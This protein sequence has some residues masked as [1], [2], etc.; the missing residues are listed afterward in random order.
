MARRRSNRDQHLLALALSSQWQFSA[1]IAGVC[2]VGTYIGLPILFH[3]PLLAPLA[4]SLR[5]LGLLLAAVFGAIAAAK[6]FTGRTSTDVASVLNINPSTDPFGSTPPARTRTTDVQD[7][8]LSSGSVRPVAKPTA[9]SLDVLRSIEWKR[10][11]E[12]VAAYFREKGARTET[13]RCGADGGVD[14]TLYQGDQRIGVVQCKA[15]NSRPV[16]VKPV[17]ELLGVMADQKIAKGFFMATGDYTNEAKDFA[18]TNPIT[19]MTGDS[20]LGSISRMPSDAQQRLLAVATEGDY[21]MP[22]CPSCGIKM[23]IR[24][25]ER[26]D[27][28]GCRNYPRCRAKF[29]LRTGAE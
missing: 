17:R 11:E 21:T 28:W 14:A 4:L 1:V 7:L 2:L 12:L 22:T 3:G 19:L 8:P 6:F 25:S 27:F 10:F 18:K 13:I 29:V 16:G 20:F 15:W 9:W 23:V 26:G 5:S 24:N